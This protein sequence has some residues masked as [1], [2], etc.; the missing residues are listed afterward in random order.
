MFSCK[1]KKFSA[2]SKSEERQNSSNNHNHNCIR[3]ENKIAFQ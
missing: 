2:L 3:N 1:A